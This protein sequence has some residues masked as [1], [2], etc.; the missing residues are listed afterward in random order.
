ML[1][2]ILFFIPGLFLSF[3]LNTLDRLL[4]T[5]FGP[6]FESSLASVEVGEPTK[7]SSKARR[8]PK[9]GESGKLL[10]SVF[11]DVTTASELFTKAVQENS[12][13]NCLGWRE[14]KKIHKEIRTLDDGRKKEW[15]IPEFGDLKY[16]T[17]AEVGQRV[18]EIGSGLVKFANLKPSDFVGIFEDTRAEWLMAAHAVFQQALTLVTVY[19][20]LGEEA[21]IACINETKLKVL[22]VNG[23]QVNRLISLRDK[24]PNLEYLVYTDKITGEPPKGDHKI[25]IISFE[26][27]R[28][29]GAKN[30]VE[31]KVKPKPKDLA[32]IMYTSG[33][34]GKQ[35]LCNYLFFFRYAKGCY[36]FTWK[37][38][39]WSC[40]CIKY[41]TCGN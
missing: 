11:E 9:I 31:P 39:C 20:S 6:S 2:K 27:L 22:V 4:N 38:C 32:L 7:N 21:L 8:H 14:V 13:Q 1:F 17:Y 5:F 24:M 26:E 29:L 3:A 36:D 12:N 28:Q 19:A 15:L 37:Y 30:I 35:N 23:K 18:K 34:T 10:A 25:K 40:I 16:L 33:T 41:W